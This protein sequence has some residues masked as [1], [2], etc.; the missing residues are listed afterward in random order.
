MVD[1]PLKLIN[2][3]HSQMIVK[4]LNLTFGVKSYMK[5]QLVPK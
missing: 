5:R 4:A 2:L 1:M 3:F